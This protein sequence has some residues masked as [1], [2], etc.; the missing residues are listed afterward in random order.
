MTTYKNRNA[1]TKYENSYAEIKIIF[2]N[3]KKQ[4]M[5]PNIT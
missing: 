2:K 4:E 3:K 1:Y 5:Y